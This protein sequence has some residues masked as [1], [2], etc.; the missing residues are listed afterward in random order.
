MP[1][2]EASPQSPRSPRSPRPPQAPAHTPPV[3]PAPPAPRPPSD[4]L[5]ALDR[6]ERFIW[7]T[8]RVLEQRRF[9][10]HFLGGDADPVDTALGSY[11]NPDGGYGHALDPDLRGPLSQPLHTA[12]ALRVLDGLGRCAGQRIE[13]L[14][15]HL[16]GVST[17]DGA[18]PVV[19][20][21]PQDYPT[22]PYHLVH[23]NPA[24][25]LLTTGPVVGLLHRN[26]VWHAWLFRATDFCWDRVENLHRTHPY[27]VQSAVAFLDGVPDRAR[28]AAAA[29][30]LGRLVREQRLV[31]LDP[32]RR[33]D[34][35][36]APGYAPGE[37]LFPHDFARR[38]ESLARGW[39][40]DEE[41]R[42]SLDFLAA[43][44]QADGGWPV[45]RE[46][47]APGSSLERRP[48]ATLEALLTLRAYGRLPARVSRP[49]PVPPR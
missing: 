14:C 41:M 46:A 17:P 23:D 48:I 43:A 5:P 37:Q 27:E 29:D 16:T 10:F 6:A 47:W 20:P 44:Q 11:L 4:P 25:E 22:A 34:F 26:R 32:R 7:L 31:V 38:P 42:R 36:P 21:A 30:R 15:R 49:G 24:G 40:T 1:G 13:R 12:H 19:F 9:A 33:A 39:F 18:L 3:P 8:A 28:A 2:D 35:P 45:R